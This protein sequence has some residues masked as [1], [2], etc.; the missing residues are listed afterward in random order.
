MKRERCVIICECKVCGS[1]TISSPNAS[2]SIL[3][4]VTTAANDD[5][6]SVA[7]PVQ[8]MDA[9]EKEHQKRIDELKKKRQQELKKVVEKI[10][11]LLI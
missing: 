5:Q 9:M 4:E 8:N 10:A 1:L 2:A 6:E 7:L 11:I 3:Q